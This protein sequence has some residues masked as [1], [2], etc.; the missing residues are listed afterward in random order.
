MK[1]EIAVGIGVTL[2]VLVGGGVVLARNKKKG[3][4]LILA[5][6][7]EPPK[8]LPP[9]K[10]EGDTPQPTPVPRPDPVHVIIKDGNGDGLYREASETKH[11]NTW[12][13]RGN[14]ISLRQT[15]YA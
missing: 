12:Y 6:G 5:T 3:D 2:A 8:L 14:L 7:E 1:K 15:H 10:K 4:A 13:G 11:W 9:P